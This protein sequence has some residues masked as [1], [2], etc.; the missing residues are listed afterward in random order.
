MTKTIQHPDAA[1]YTVG[2]DGS[3]FPVK[4]EAEHEK[5]EPFSDPDYIPMDV[6]VSSMVRRKHFHYSSPRTE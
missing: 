4:V 5:D 3:L 2:G 6:F 1:V